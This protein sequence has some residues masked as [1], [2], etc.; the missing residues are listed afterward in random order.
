MGIEIQISD[1]INGVVKQI[2]DHA[3]ERM[4]EAVQAVRNT[5]LETLSGSRS[6]RTYHVPGTKKEY[7]ASSPGEAP[8]QATGTLRQSIKSG[9]EKEGKNIIG[10]VG[11]EEKYG[12]MLEFGTKG[13]AVIRPKT[14]KSLAWYS[15]GEMHFAQMVI[16]GPI[17]PR[18]W[19]RPSFIKAEDTI[20]SIFTRRWF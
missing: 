9:I 16:Q 20:K 14:A 13:G 18:P 5:T 10:F 1:N 19:L 8:A 4:M 12:A 2:Q 17:L 15:D 11:T 6:G 3:E 7:T